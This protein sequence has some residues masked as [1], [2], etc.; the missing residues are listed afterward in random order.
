M[1]TMHRNPSKVA[2][3]SLEASKELVAC[4]D[5]QAGF[6]EKFIP[7]SGKKAIRAMPSIP[8]QYVGI[9]TATRGN[10]VYRVTLRDDSQYRAEPV[11]D[12]A[13]GA[14]ILSGSWGAYDGS[15]IWMHDEG[16]IWPPD[17]N[18]ITPI[19][20]ASFN[21]READGS[22]TRYDLIERV[23]STSCTPN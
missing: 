22:I 11:R 13:P 3:S 6:P 2:P 7:D 23:P 9:W 17:I 1:E 5:T 20:D 14:K 16:R 19:S 18:P 8:C 10:T 4:L 12:D 15:M 21:L